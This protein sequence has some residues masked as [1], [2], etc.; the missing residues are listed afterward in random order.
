LNG[1]GERPIAPLGGYKRYKLA[2]N[3]ISPRALPGTPGFEHVVATDDHDEDGGL[4]SDEFTNPHKRRAMH[5]KR[6][7]KMDGL[8]PL[9]NP[10]KL[11]GPATAQVTLVGWGSTA[12][13]IREAV[14]KLA[15]EECGVRDELQVKW[16]V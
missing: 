14:E 12:G 13:V 3:G 2:E 4:I 11:F 6:M 7:R 8:L 9:I 10:P 15:S 16:P 1:N 5:E